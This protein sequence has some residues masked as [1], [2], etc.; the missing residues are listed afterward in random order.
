ML[1]HAPLDSLFPFFL[2]IHVVFSRLMSSLP[3][4]QHRRKSLDSPFAVRHP[5]TTGEPGRGLVQGVWCQPI[6]TCGRGCPAR[7][8]RP[9][10]RSNSDM[11]ALAI[12]STK[13]AVS[14]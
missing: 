6:C 5:S 12:T 8:V 10:M 4:S 3:D 1:A 14:E 13:P 2:P 9:I 7:C 11:G